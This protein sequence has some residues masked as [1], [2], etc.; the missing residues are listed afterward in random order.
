MDIPRKIEELKVEAGELVD[1][2]KELIHEGSV[3]R[4]IIKDASGHTFMELPLSIAAIGVI[5]VPVLSALGAL[6]AMVANFTVVVE[7]TEKPEAPVSE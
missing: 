5:A 6:A 3:R 7:R 2:V 4:I 1:K